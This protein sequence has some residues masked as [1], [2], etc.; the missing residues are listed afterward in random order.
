MSLRVVG[1]SPAAGA[2]PGGD[3]PDGPLAR[4]AKLVPAEALGLYSAGL[5]V[6]HSASEGQRDAMLAA[7]AV[8][9]LV[10]CIFVRVRE[11]A[12]SDGKPQVRA[13]G[14]ALISFVIWLCML[15]AGSSPLPIQGA[16]LTLVAIAWGT[17]I[18]FIYKGA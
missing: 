18:P 9:A 7:W 10:F 12:G 8:S 6:I 2:V 17:M 4:I 15:P 16:W 13:I 3:K 5:P 1:T 14:I 11:T